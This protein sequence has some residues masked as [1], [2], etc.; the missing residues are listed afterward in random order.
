MFKPEELYNSPNTLAEYYS[1]FKVTE[2]LLLTGHSHQAWPDCGFNGQKKA[3]LDAAEYV[4]DKWGKAFE[5]ADEVKKGYLRLL[6]DDSGH[7]TLSSNTHE[8][9]VRFLSA[10]PINKE[11]NIVTTD[12]EFHTIRRQLDRLAEEGITII[13]VESSP[14]GLVTEKLVSNINNKTIAVLVSKV[15]FNSGEIVEDLS[16]VVHRC[17]EMGAKLLVD[18]YHALNVVPFSIKDEKLE[19]AFVVGGGYKYCQL[20]E[21]NCFLRFPENT[22]LRPVITGWYSEYGT[23]S[24]AKGKG[25]TL[26]GSGDDLFAGATYDPTAN[27]RAAEVFNFFKEQ[28]L[29]PGF[30]R[31]VNQHQISLLAGEFDQMDTDPKIISRNKNLK[32]TEMGGFLVLYSAYANEISSR[33]KEEGVWTDYR[34]NRL[35]LGPAPYLSDD[36]LKTSMDI[37]NNVI[38]N[39]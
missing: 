22:S 19:D 36:Q 4:D 12:G 7:I 25:E 39:F 28:N 8:L 5:K 29:T 1:K 14:A 30:L 3:W 38:S 24:K 20:G 17:E 9:I 10:L 23:L 32:I 2:R 34:G 21:G 16:Q 18:A 31:N 15:F 27:Y 33:L 37:F 11:I 26:Y 35:R 6:D 13:K